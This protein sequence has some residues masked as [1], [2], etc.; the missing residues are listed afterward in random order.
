M[1]TNA[2]FFGAMI[3]P[4]LPLVFDYFFDHDYYENHEQESDENESR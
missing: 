1:D 4:W 2:V 3:V